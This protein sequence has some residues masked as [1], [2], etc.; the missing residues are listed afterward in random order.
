MRKKREFAAGWLVLLVSLAVISANGEIIPSTNRINWASVAGI[1]GGIPQRTVIFTN[2]SNL[3]T[4]GST[5][6][7]PA[8]QNAVN[9]CPPNQVVQL[10]PGRLRLSGSLQM[11]DF[12]TVRGSGA[13]T[14]LL[15]TGTIYFSGG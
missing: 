13:T 14:K 5:D 8:L 7:L 9:R 6:V 11:R 10:P 4:S 3:D 12:V 1:E 2:L 15:P